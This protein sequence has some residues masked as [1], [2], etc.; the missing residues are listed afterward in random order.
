MS[1]V[2]HEKSKV[3]HLYNDAI[4]Y[5]MMVMEN[6]H[7]G[8]LYC[9]KRIHDRE[10]FSYLLEKAPRPMSSYVY[11]NERLF[12]LEHIR[13]EF[14]VYGTTDYRHPAVEVRQ[15]NGSRISEFHYQGYH[16]F[17]GK[18]ELEGL[19]ATYTEEASEAETLVV[20]VKD[21]LTGVKAELSY[22]IFREGG[23]LARN[24]RFLKVFI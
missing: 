6:G 15:N 16:V 5:I 2:F 1:I 3:F 24:V 7:L 4:S 13:Q 21:A 23:I 8:Q 14:P 22:T 10:D 19:P 11:E 20:D 12:S 17:A 18:P 9:G